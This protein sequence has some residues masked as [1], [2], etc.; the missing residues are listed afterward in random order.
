MVQ[1]KAEEI[2][3]LDPIMRQIYSRKK[4]IYDD[5]PADMVLEDLLERAHERVGSDGYRN[6]SKELSELDGAGGVPSAAPSPGAQVMTGAG[7][8]GSR[9]AA[10]P[11]AGGNWSKTKAFEGLMRSGSDSQD[12]MK[13]TTEVLKERGF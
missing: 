11:P 4:A 6:L 7:G 1:E 13:S 9:R 5:L 12:E 8:G 2:Q 3:V 10:G